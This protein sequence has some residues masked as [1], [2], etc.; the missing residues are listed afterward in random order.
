MTVKEKFALLSGPALFALVLIF[1]PAEGMGNAARGVLASALW[2]A[3]WWITEAVPI[4]ATSLLPLI[5]FPLTGGLDMTA[6]ATPYGSPMIFLYVGGFIIALGVEKWNLHRRI[7]LNIIN[8]LGTES[9]RLVLGFM[10]ATAFLSMWI[11]NTATAM[12]MM[13][14]GV[15]IVKQLR[16]LDNVSEARAT[17]FGKVLMLAIA[18]ACSIGGMATLIGTPTNVAFAG[19]VREMY[20][21]EVPFAKWF[22][23]G[24]PVTLCL[25]SV[26]WFYL[27]RFVAPRFGVSN[28]SADKKYIEKELSKLGPM[29]YVEKMVLL[30]FSLTALCW[31]TRSFLLIHIIPGI[32]DTVVAVAFALL[33]FIIP[34]RDPGTRRILV[35]EDTVKLPWGIVLLFGGGLSVAAGFK[36]SGLAEWM[37]SQ[38][39][40]LKDVPLIFLILVV[41]LMVNFLTEITSNVA[42]AS[43][44]LPVMASLASA[45]EVHPYGLMIAATVAASCAFM[46]PVATPPNAVVFGS[47]YLRIVDM[48]RAGFP[49]NLISSII[50]TL[51]VYWLLPSIWGF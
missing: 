18:Y 31:I 40:L 35:W 28:I 46:L 21:Q 4:P 9:S 29:R 11:S 47:G 20:A 38:L 17:G 39:G 44:L 49:M 36:G 23:F 15:A 42:T 5:L 32:D 22:L 24:M 43:M 14:I 26:A 45:M 48:V 3:T 33:L 34:S 2:I 27:T 37:G 8:Y 13:P 10:L 1:V 12:M 25:L 41:V 16:S 7:A 30:V 6:T 50:L 51:L 19:V